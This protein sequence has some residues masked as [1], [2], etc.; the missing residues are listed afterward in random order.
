MATKGVRETVRIQVLRA[1]GGIRHVSEA[2]A[3]LRGLRNGYS[4]D[5]GVWFGKV[6][7]HGVDILRMGRDAE[8]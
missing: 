8:K 4:A 3:L 5:S 2:S 1:P 6:A 7:K